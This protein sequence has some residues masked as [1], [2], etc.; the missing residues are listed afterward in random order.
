MKEQGPT[1]IDE[2]LL[3]GATWRRNYLP[4]LHRGLGAAWFAVLVLG[5]LGAAL[6]V[7]HRHRPLDRIVGLVALAGVVAYL[8]TPQSGGVPF[9]FNLRYLSPMLLVG[10]VVLPLSAPTTVR[11]RWGQ[12]LVSV[13]LVAIG[14]TASHHER[15]PAWPGEA[16]L[17]GV[18][19]ALAATLFVVV[20][21]RRPA[22]KRI[23]PAVLVALLAAVVAISGWPLQRE[24]LEHRY[25]GRGL[26]P[27]N[28]IPAYFRGVRN[29]RVIVF[30]E[31]E[32]YPLFGLDLSN[33]VTLGSDPPP[34]PSHDVCRWWR[35]RLGDHYDYI[36][37][38]TFG[39]GYF[40]RPP[41]EVISDDPASTTV[42][43]R[44]HSAIYRLRGPLHPDRCPALPG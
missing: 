26:L 11:W 23:S 41:E 44:G 39:F 1:L 35:K 13:C 2:G 40:G 6:M 5:I 43:H 25:A 22:G 7:F 17:P 10:L 4:G 27:D 34:R 30:G 19:A 38:T 18:V 42:L 8:F 31:V 24:Y 37:V 32:S 36:A 16:L 3:D 9:V 28:A 15:V 29:A 14:A 21:L 33:R 20:R 12:L